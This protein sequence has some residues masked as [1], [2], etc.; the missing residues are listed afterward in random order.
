[1]H[2][3]YF[4]QK[5]VECNVPGNEKVEVLQTGLTTEGELMVIGLEV[6]PR[7]LRKELRKLCWISSYPIENSRLGICNLGF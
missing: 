2:I 7:A 1:M 5:A 3:D 6:L 4:T